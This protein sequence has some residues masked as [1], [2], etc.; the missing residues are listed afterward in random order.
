MA[1][2]TKKRDSLEPAKQPSKAKKGKPKALV[3]AEE[4]EQQPAE[5]SPEEFAKEMFGSAD[6]PQNGLPSLEWLKGQFQTKSAAVRYLV[7]QQHPIKVIAKHLGMRYQH[8]RNVANQHLK[9]GPNEDWRK[10]LL[11]QNQ[12]QNR[13]NSVEN[14]STEPQEEYDGDGEP[15]PQG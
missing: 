7:N 5:Q 2:S 14:P 13:P 1:K 12:N 3:E 4:A 10:P 8:V 11:N 6:T 9:R 15:S